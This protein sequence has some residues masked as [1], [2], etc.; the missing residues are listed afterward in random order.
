ML[1]WGWNFSYKLEIT[2]KLFRKLFSYKNPKK[3]TIP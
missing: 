3:T 1:I 2:Y